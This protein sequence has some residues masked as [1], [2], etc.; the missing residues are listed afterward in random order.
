[1]V[2]V[3]AD[4][5]GQPSFMLEGWEQRFSTTENVFFK[6]SETNGIC[7][8]FM[9]EFVELD[10]Y[11]GDVYS[12][13]IG[14]TLSLPSEA[15][16]EVEIIHELRVKILEY[17][18]QLADASRVLGELDW[19][20]PLLTANKSPISCVGGRKVQFNTACRNGRKRAQH[21]RR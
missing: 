19:Y 11:Y 8:I 13:I 9:T 21:R 20:F 14:M 7:L 15:D 17:S 5:D 2:T 1:L 4:E 18:T 16:R 6:C 12:L 10:E 3:P